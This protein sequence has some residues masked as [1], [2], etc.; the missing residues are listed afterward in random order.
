MAEEITLLESFDHG[1]TGWRNYDTYDPALRES[2]HNQ[3]HVDLRDF[4]PG[5]VE[6]WNLT[7]TVAPRSGNGNIR[8]FR[9]NF[10]AGSIDVTSSRA[11]GAGVDMKTGFEDTDH[12]SVAFPNFPLSSINLA[13]SYIRFRCDDSS[14]T[15]ALS[16][17]VFLNNSVVPMTNGN[18]EFRV[19]LSSIIYQNSF[20][21]TH[22]TSILMHFVTTASGVIEIN[23]VRTL[24]A[25]W[26][27]GGLDMNTLDKSLRLSPNRTGGTAADFTQPILW[28]S[29]EPAGENDPRP[30]DA[31]F[32]VPFQTS[33]ATTGTNRISLYFRELTEDFMTQLDLDGMTQAELNGRPQPDVGQAKYNQRTIGELNRYKISELNDETIFSLERTPDFLS[34]SWI[35]FT[36]QWGT[37][38][39]ISLQDTEG[40]GYSFDFTTLTT[41]TNY[42]FATFLEENKARAALYKVGSDGSYVSTVFDTTMINDDTAFQRRKGR[43]GW[44]ANLNDGD[45]R[46]LA[47]APNGITYAEYRS[48][49]YTSQTPVVGSEL[50]A[51]NSP[52]NELFE[53][54][55]V[56][57]PSQVTVNRD[58]TKSLSG[59]SWRVDAPV[60][61]GNTKFYTQPLIITDYANSI[62]EFDLFVP[63]SVKNP[64]LKTTVKG[65]NFGETYRLITPSIYGD[66]WQHIR[67]DFLFGTPVILTG[68]I[69]IEFMLTTD[70]DSAVAY[71]IDNMS[72]RER[73]VI[74]DGRA[75]VDDPWKSNDAK[76]QHFRDNYARESGG[77]V[78]DKRGANLQ[79]R[80]RARKQT[81]TISRV[82]YKPRYAELGRAVDSAIPLPP[83]YEYINLISNPN[84]DST[85]GWQGIS[86]NTLTAATDGGSPALQNVGTGTRNVYLQTQAT[87]IP[88]VAG[89]RYFVAVQTRRSTANLNFDISVGLAVWDS[90]VPTN[91]TYGAFGAHFSNINTSYVEI[92]FATTLSAATIASLGYTAPRIGLVLDWISFLAAGNTTF[93]KRATLVAFP[94]TTPFPVQPAIAFDGNTSNAQWLGAPPSQSKLTMNPF[95]S[96]PVISYTATNAGLVVTLTATTN[97]PIINYEWNFGDGEKGIGQKVVHTFPTSGV[98][99]V[100]LVATDSYG[101][102]ETYLNTVAV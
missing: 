11:N 45:S 71:W 41:G 57:A 75:V 84:G 70:S 35:E 43:M 61:I 9:E 63:S 10:T 90:A 3:R 54:F 95:Y 78:F 38:N 39:K 46:I 32:V 19:P 86:G 88:W 23:A 5:S 92:S 52:A 79:V 6:N 20:D 97:K 60:D 31:N 58:T 14:Y 83:T 59:E 17:T 74:W 85:I 67:I 102:Q 42:V 8:S 27:F 7:G 47:I 91:V 98:Y 87:S 26:R 13:S 33:T 64:V 4:M 18:S 100:S 40:N 94:D 30:I 25:N 99:P 44:Y 69:Q 101:N 16:A 89:T 53:E 68:L 37:I 21:P 82:Q 62:I 76:W 56:L 72:V 48:L 80:G 49:P 96:P 2:I 22:V 12:F 51:T 34:A 77:I 1:P 66:Q 73:T 28:H 50:F 24:A 55:V 15:L 81:A 93:M 36:L 65:F 29:A